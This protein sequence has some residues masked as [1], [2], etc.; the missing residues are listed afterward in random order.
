M[1]N[2]LK[3]AFRNTFRNGRRTLLNLIMI[4]GGVTAIILFRG[5]AA[6]MLYDVREKTIESQS[7]HLA[8][9]TSQY[10]NETARHPKQALLPHY[11]IIADVIHK[12][13]HVRYVAGRLN[14]YGLLSQGEKSLSAR[15]IS[16]DPAVEKLKSQSLTMEEGVGLSPDKPFQLILGTGLAKKLH[17]KVG[18]S[19][20][21][22]AYTF[23]NVIN[24]FDL[25]VAGI[26]RSGLSEVDQATF[27]MP[28]QTTQ[29]L[30]DTPDVEQI[31]VGLDDTRNTDRV[32]AELAPQVRAIN[33]DVTIKTWSQLSDFYHQVESFFR[34][35]NRVI[36]FI[37]LALILLGVLNTIGMSV[38]ERAG[39]I[40]TERALG[41]TERSVLAQFLTEGAILGVAGAAVGA[42]VGTV[43]AIVVSSL[44]LLIVVPG[45]SRP[46][47][48]HIDLF[49]A[50][51][52][53]AIVLAFIAACLAALGPAYRA[54]HMNIVDAL[55]RNV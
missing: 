46:I 10:W 9:A 14:F 16:L 31:V 28:F 12:N 51:Y 15:G 50:E 55:R 37:L 24:A 21:V 1:K 17:A 44:G 23:D 5:F 33:P 39:E 18:D 2:R 49:P 52:L 42:I 19:L 11:Q 48:L 7:G 53:Q 41:E 27:M 30:L 22:L 35:Q 32:E 36:E 45:A 20:T 4:A 3:I 47:H 54:A 13:P 26:F 43:L 29:K 6:R 8:L 40:G 34:V 25:E 38:F